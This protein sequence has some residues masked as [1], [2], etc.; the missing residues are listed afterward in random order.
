M[1]VYARPASLNAVLDLMADGTWR[2]LAGG[3]DLYPGAGAKLAMPV[4]DV[5]AVPD[6][7]ALRQTDDGLR[8]GAGV[9]W[10]TLS[11]AALPPALMGLQQAARQVGARQVQNA[12]TIGGNLCNASP[13]ADGVPPLLTLDA[14]VELASHR[15]IR[16]LPLAEFLLGPRQTARAADEVM[17]AVLVPATALRGQGQF[18]KLGARAYLVISIVMVAGRVAVDAGRVSDIALAVGACSAVAQRL[19]KVEQALLGAPVDALDRLVKDSDVADALAPIADVRATAD[20]R[21]TAAVE[22]VRRMVRGLV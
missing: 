18:L 11:E 12:G 22:L 21:N 17:T 6:L 1:T 7:R 13:A 2:V 15:G 14:L 4:V 16:T 9:T 3:T 20:Y 5:S 19:P 8:I 10:A